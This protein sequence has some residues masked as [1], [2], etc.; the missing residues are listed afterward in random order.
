MKICNVTLEGVSQYSQSRMHSAPKMEQEGA[1]EY[2]LRTALEYLH[3]D[4]RT[5]QV[6]I[7]PMAVKQSIEGA[8]KY[9]QRRIPGKGQATY[10]KHFKS[11]LVVAEPIMVFRADGSPVLKHECEVEKL[12]LNADGVRGGGKRVWKYYPYIAAGWRGELRAHII[13]DTL[14]E[15]SFLQHLGEAGIFIGLGRF[16]PRNGGYYG[17]FSIVQGSAQWEVVRNAVAF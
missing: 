13:D 3:V 12:W 17:R 6:F 9:M 4:P 2:A 7:P 10:T 1:D 16:S 8:A 11:G 15:E 5:K 14:T